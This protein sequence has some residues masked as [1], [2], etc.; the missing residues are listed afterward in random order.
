[1]L[2]LVHEEMARAGD[3][4]DVTSARRYRQR[5]VEG[6]AA[7]RRSMTRTPGTADGPPPT[8]GEAG[9]ASIGA[10]FDRPVGGERPGSNAEASAPICSP[11]PR[12]RPAGRRQS[13]SGR[14]ARARSRIQSARRG[15]SRRS[16]SRRGVGL[17]L[18]GGE[19]SRRSGRCRRRSRPRSS[20]SRHSPRVAD[21]ESAAIAQKRRND[22]AEHED[23]EREDDLPGPSLPSAAAKN[24]GPTP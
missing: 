24:C 12:R 21:I 3:G 16:R 4:D 10:Q 2:D 19:S 5:A 20:G 18:F 17:G 6:A 22:E 15:R 7:R 8:S 1:M 9:V 14:S 13:A 11:S 23:Q